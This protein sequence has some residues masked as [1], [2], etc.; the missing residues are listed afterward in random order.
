MAASGAAEIKEN[1]LQLITVTYLHFLSLFA[2][3]NMNK[4][5]VVPSV[6]INDQT[7][8]EGNCYIW[9]I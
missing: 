1:S 4:V 9:F 2:L 8:N 7:F 5:F 3:F 6:G